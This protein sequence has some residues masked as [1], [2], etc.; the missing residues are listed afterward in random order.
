MEVT[1]NADAVPV[2]DR[3]IAQYATRKILMI[4]LPIIFENVDH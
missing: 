1:V 4:V 2:V 3:R